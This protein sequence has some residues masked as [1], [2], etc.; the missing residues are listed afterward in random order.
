MEMVGQT[1]GHYRIL[2]RIGAGGMGEV[3]KAEDTR[4][5]RPVALKFLPRE[6]TR[7]TT[8]RRRLV[9]EARAA[10]ALDHP[11]ICGVHEIGETPDG[12]MYICMVH[13]E[14]ETLKA[15]LARGP[16]VL[17]EILA[18]AMQ[19]AQG[20]AFAHQA[21]VVHRDVKPANIIVTRRG[22][23][24]ILDF[25]L[26]KLADRTQITESGGTVG[27]AAYMSPEQARGLPVDAR[28]DVWSFG[29]VLYEMLAGRN[30]FLAE[31]PQATIYSILNET[32]PPVTDFRTDTPPELARI[33]VAA[34][35]KTPD[36]RPASMAGLLDPLIDFRDSLN[37]SAARGLRRQAAHFT[38]RYGWQLATLLLLVAAAAGYLLMTRLPPPDADRGAVA[39]L[40]ATHKPKIYV[41][42]VKIGATLDGAQ[43]LSEIL[44]FLMEVD[45]FQS[46]Y[47]SVIKQ[48]EGATHRIRA[49]YLEGS[50]CRLQAAILDATTQ[51]YIA[52]AEVEL[53]EPAEPQDLIDALTP[54]IKEALQ[55]S[56]ESIAGDIDAALRDVTTSSRE[57]LRLYVEARKLYTSGRFNES[58][59]RLEQATALDP[60]F[61]LAYA[62]LS[63]NYGHLRELE[64]DRQY[65][66]KALA[67]K[68]RL[69]PRERFDLELLNSK[70]TEVNYLMRA[71]LGRRYDALYPNDAEIKRKVGAIF[72]NAEDWSEASKWFR[73]AAAADPADHLAVLNLAE[74]DIRQGL[75]ASARALL[76]RNRQLF[77]DPMPYQ[78]RLAWTYLLEH[79]Y[80]QARQEL[81][82]C[83]DLPREKSWLHVR[84]AAVENLCGRPAEA[85]R[86]LRERIR[87]ADPDQR[88]MGRYV[89]GEFLLGRGRY[90][91]SA[92]VLAE[93]LREAETLGESAMKVD[94]ALLTA[95]VAL[96]RGDPAAALRHAESAGAASPALLD[97]EYDALAL[98]M[99]GL[100]QL[101]QGRAEAAADTAQRLQALEAATGMA[102]LR[103]HFFH[104]SAAMALHR[105]DPRRAAASMELA[106]P[107]LDWTPDVRFFGSPSLYLPLLGESYRAAGRIDKA[108]GA[109]TRL[110]DSAASRLNTSDSY[111][112]ALLN[113]GRCARQRGQEQSARRHF[114]QLLELWRQA[115]PDR[116]E[117]KEAAAGRP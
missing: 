109:L 8:A 82:Q 78:G 3:Y 61:A 57:A 25:G 86:I 54:K 16:M 67:L 42:P 20:L 22:D 53:A 97:P 19:I 2:E 6:L 68:E 93:G 26:A 51:E 72:R 110:R 18:V 117:L 4:L 17:D 106:I 11:N 1:V 71:D 91:E 83:L 40:A 21:G 49:M 79:Q 65:L 31:Y 105:G 111:A 58:I 7:D 85:E 87:H 62:Q 95:Y 114:N 77:K 103:R 115:D 113:L 104:L 80:P 92:Q 37:G 84:L 74:I 23:V 88:M 75:A 9:Q 15:R 33:L 101:A 107:L 100:A 28:T 52:S 55:F 60:D 59:A 81:I 44:T 36:H 69:S 29:V 30:P 102:K 34:L 32:P 48:P 89:L 76:V 14:G 35:S 96:R 98:H 5:H 10:S 70:Y 116:P 43:N 73:E 108:V 46:R 47:L 39:A 45:L 64:K 24:K 56:P 63:V 41:E 112:L 38:R 66:Q 94:L 90:G 12:R 27:T 50:A 99:Q 13:Y